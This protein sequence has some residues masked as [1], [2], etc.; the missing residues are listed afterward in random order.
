LVSWQSGEH[1]SYPA[2]PCVT[3]IVDAYLLGGTMPD[4][5]ALCPP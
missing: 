5:G 3:G 2:S 4:V 1:G